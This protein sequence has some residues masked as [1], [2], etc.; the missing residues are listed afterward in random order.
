MC[1]NNISQKQR[2]CGKIN[3][4]LKGKIKMMCTRARI[5]DVRSPF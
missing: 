5:R 4:I 3:C 2:M 1:L